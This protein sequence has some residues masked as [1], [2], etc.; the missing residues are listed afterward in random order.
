M[1][2]SDLLFVLGGC[3]FLRI[4]SFTII[5][6]GFGVWGFLFLF[7]FFFKYICVHCAMSVWLQHP[8]KIGL[9]FW[10]YFNSQPRCWFEKNTAKD[11][12]K[13]LKDSTL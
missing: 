5:G 3:L 13:I 7:F 10:N 2:L 8:L 4:K 6:L 9:L 1:L 12:H 11:R